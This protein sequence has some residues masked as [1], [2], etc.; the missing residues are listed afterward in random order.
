M[1]ISNQII[2]GRDWLQHKV[3]GIDPAKVLNPEIPETTMAFEGAE[4]AAEIKKAIN[5]FKAFA[6][7]ETG[8]QVNYARLADSAVYQTYCACVFQLQKFDLR[9]LKTPAEQLAFWINLYNTLVVD[10]VIQF[11][12]QTSVTEG[13]LGILAFFERA[14]YQI[15]GMRFSLTD[16][17][18]GILRG[19]R[20]FPYFPGGHFGSDDP[21][22][23]YILDRV[24]PRI[25]FALNCASQSCPPIG[26]YSADGIDAQL[27]LATLNF[28]G[29]NIQ[30]DEAKNQISL[31]SIF[32]WYQVDFGGTAGII[33]FVSRN[34]PP[35]DRKKW[36][37][38]NS[39]DLRLKFQPNDWGL[40]AG[41]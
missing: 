20:G 40:N 34:L 39:K 37:E 13:P 36:L 11:Q 38:S 22:R 7:D 19:N 3:M 18:H 26:V 2:R 5:M 14:A 30:V 33:D 25:H 16:I 32:K 29:A 31:S 27:D 24:D 4:L 28:M 41:I 15:D 17:E 9:N 8:H 6:M 1:R 21:R 35:G 23:S 10:A 12:V